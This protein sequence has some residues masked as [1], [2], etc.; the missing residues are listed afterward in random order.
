MKNVS[1][2]VALLASVAGPAWAQSS[3]TVYGVLDAAA[4]YQTKTNPQGKALKSLQ[5]NGQGFQSGNRIGFKGTEDLGD[6]LR[7][8]FVLEQGLLVDTGTLDQQGQAFGRQSYVFIGGAYGDLALGR[9]YTTANTMM[10]FVEPLGVG[11][12]ASNAWFVYLTGQ[13]F[14]NAITYNKTVGSFSVM[15]EHALGEN[16]QSTSAM[17]STGI[18]LRYSVPGLNLTGNYQQSQDD[19]SRKARIAMV[20]AKWSIGSFDLYGNYLNSQRDAGFD[21]S[22]GGTD[23]ASITSMATAATATNRAAINSVFGTKRR[24]DFYYV[25]AGSRMSPQVTILG[26]LIR[27]RTTADGFSGTRTTIYGMVDYRLSKRTDLYAAAVVDRVGGDWS[28]LLGN[29]TTAY[30]GGSGAKLNGNDSQTSLFL[31]VRHAF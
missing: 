13:R 2:I 11:A 28:G 19:Q 30:T 6:G 12:A 25:G 15:L 27:D 14:N 29:T 7:A 4:V 10:Y 1:R 23:T 8:G 16:A 9:Q 20:G 5:Q 24:D 31:G 26:N 22:R 18:G 17:S 21:S 3:V